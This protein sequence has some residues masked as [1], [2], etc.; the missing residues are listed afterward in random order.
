MFIDADT[1]TT[2]PL[3]SYLYHKHLPS[4]L[5]QP[6]HPRNRNILSSCIRSPPPKDHSPNHPIR[7]SWQHIS[8]TASS[9]NRIYL[10]CNPKSPQWTILLTRPRGA[11][12]VPFQSLS[13]PTTT[14]LASLTVH[15]APIRILLEAT[16]VGTHIERTC[17]SIL[18]LMDSQ[19]IKTQTT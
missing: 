13:T 11:F 17:L 12:Q 9:C 1:Y 15:I 7:L 19:P 6:T 18:A 16:L 14:R 2:F 8:R 10:E 3:A 4:I 5:N